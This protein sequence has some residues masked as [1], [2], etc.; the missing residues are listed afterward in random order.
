MCRVNTVQVTHSKT[1]FQALKDGTGTLHS[2]GKCA[3]VIQATFSKG[4]SSFQLEISRSM[5]TLDGDTGGGL[6]TT[7]YRY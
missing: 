6:K 5:P 3:E 7:S 4:E 2:K 1:V